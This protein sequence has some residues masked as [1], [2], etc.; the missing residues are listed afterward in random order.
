[1]HERLSEERLRAEVERLQ[2]Q[3]RELEAHNR[4]LQEQARQ[5]DE[6][7]KKQK[8]AWM[9]WV[10]ARGGET[11]A[12]LAKRDWSS[13][14]I[15]PIESWPE[16]LCNAISICL[17]SRFPMVVAWGTEYV[18]LYNDA[19]IPIYGARHPHVLGGEMVMNWPEIWEDQLY[20]MFES[21]RHSG[22]AMVLQNNPFT[23]LRNGYLEE[24]YFTYCWSPICDGEN[25]MPGL[26]QR[27][28][29]RPCRSSLNGVSAC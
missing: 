15:G 9:E 10:F 17:L 1:M 13:T 24:S 27:R 6:Q 22:N 8:R 25:R 26:I 28:S 3:N 14:S 29:R 23:I 11:G 20:P 21:I 19:M 2:A 12:I 18:S 7:V 4:E 5:K 16:S